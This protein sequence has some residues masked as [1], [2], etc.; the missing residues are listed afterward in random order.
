MRTCINI[1]SSSG[2]FFN[3]RGV[4][5]WKFTKNSFKTLLQIPLQLFHAVCFTWNIRRGTKRADN[6]WK[7]YGFAKDNP[8]VRC[9]DSSLYTREPWS[10]VIRQWKQHTDKTN[11]VDSYFLKTESRKLWKRSA[12]HAVSLNIKYNF[13]Q[14]Y[15]FSADFLAYQTDGKLPAG[16]DKR[17]A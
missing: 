2:R 14:R 6:I 17:S 9:A 16:S 5:N 8:S 12:K 4:F 11:L 13:R 3:S 10:A 15:C 7:C 1:I